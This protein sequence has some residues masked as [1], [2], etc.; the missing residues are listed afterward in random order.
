MTV[1]RYIDN[2]GFALKA[3]TKKE[4]AIELYKTSFAKVYA[5]DLDEWMRRCSDRIEMQYE[6]KMEYTTPEGFVDELIRYNLIQ[7]IN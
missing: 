7:R 4:V 1:A 3:T 6:C 5:Y 2:T